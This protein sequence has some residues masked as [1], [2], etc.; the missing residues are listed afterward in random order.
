MLVDLKKFDLIV[1]RLCVDNHNIFIFI[2]LDVLKMMKQPYLIKCFYNSLTYVIFI[3]YRGGLIF[4]VL[5][6]SLYLIT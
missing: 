2:Y 6:H 5:A 3:I 4:T 1:P